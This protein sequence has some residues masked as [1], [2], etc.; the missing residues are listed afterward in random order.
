[1]SGFH[2]ILHLYNLFNS[3]EYGAL[4]FKNCAISEVTNKK[5]EGS[6]KNKYLIWHVFFMFFL[7]YYLLLGCDFIIFT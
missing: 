4:I 7:N 1:M 6:H 3:C 2:Y 5:N